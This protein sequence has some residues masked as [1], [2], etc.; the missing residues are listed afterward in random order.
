VVFILT[1]RLAA[2]IML[3]RGSALCIRL[4][5]SHALVTTEVAR[6]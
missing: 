2:R 3:N 1:P 4:P 6:A 5:N